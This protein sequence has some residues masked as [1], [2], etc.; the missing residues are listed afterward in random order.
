[1]NGVRAVAVAA[2][3]GW[4]S[5]PATW[6][7]GPL[8]TS[9]VGAGETP[10]AP[11]RV[12]GLP[13]QSKPYTRY[14]SVTVEGQRVLRVEADSSYGN[15]VHPLRA[16]GTPRILNWRWRVDEPNPQ[17]DL[18]RKEGDDS[19]LKVCALFDLPIDAVPYV[20]RQLLR[21]ARMQS[22]D[23]LPAATVCYVW[24]ARLAPGT[25]LD[26]AFSRRIRFIVLRGPE[27]ALR[28]WVTDQRD[29]RADFLRLFAD[30][31]K[32]VVPPLVGIAIGADAD[33]T[34]RRS[35]GHVGEITL[36]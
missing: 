2:L 4:M 1:V 20:E 13:G 31:A 18:R 29:V 24:D 8:L 6:A 36:N 35:V 14:T 34:R 27:T 17:S 15:L 11:W 22:S 32:G 26:N 3:A 10:V 16:E 28:G 19:P 21:V 7:A 23:E 5:I 33:N 12:V 30:E 9:P 25:A